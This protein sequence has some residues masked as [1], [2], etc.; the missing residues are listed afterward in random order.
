LSHVLLGKPVSP[1]PSQGHAFPGH[2]LIARP[3][4]T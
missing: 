1:S 4:A 2:A 3:A